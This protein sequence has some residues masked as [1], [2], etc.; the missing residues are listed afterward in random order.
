VL[1]IDLGG[2]IYPIM[3]HKLQPRIGFGWATRAIA[4]VMFV[5]LIPCLLTIKRPMKAAKR[6]KM[7][8]TTAWKS[9]PYPLFV[10]GMTFGFVGLYI[11]LFY[12]Q[13]FALGKGVADENLGFYLLAILNAG[14]VFGRTVRYSL[15]PTHYNSNT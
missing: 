8:D 12:V 14:S 6:R 13:V 9:W 7:W 11:P 1:I 5:T 15:C 4:F 2:I 10:A 3:F